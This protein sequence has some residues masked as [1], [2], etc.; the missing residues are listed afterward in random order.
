MLPYL[1]AYMGH[2]NFSHTAYYIH[3]TPEIFLH[4]S[5][6]DLSRFENLIPEV[7]YEN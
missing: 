1:S 2:A 6:M 3:L 7:A 4:M 5:Q